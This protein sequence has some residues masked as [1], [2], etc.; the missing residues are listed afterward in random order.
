MRISASVIS[1][2]LIVAANPFCA[3]EYAL[4]ID[5][6]GAINW[7][8][9]AISEF[10]EALKLDPKLYRARSALARLYV[11]G[12]NSNKAILL[13][14]DGVKYYYPVYLTGLEKFYQYAVDL[15]LMNG[16]TVKAKDIQLIWERCL[17]TGYEDEIFLNPH[18]Y[19]ARFQLAKLFEKQG[20]LDK[21][22][23]L[24]NDGSNFFYNPTLTNI[25]E[26]FNYAIKLNIMN[27]DTTKAREIQIEKGKLLG[28]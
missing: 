18:Q 8:R 5:L 20:N 11:K 9:K 21:A 2:T 27:G 14:N 3:L 1:L 28:K 19:N 7:E 4:V 17:I 6:K 22:V 16:D 25:N 10:K 24:M 26:F 13:M 15:N 12:G 23:T